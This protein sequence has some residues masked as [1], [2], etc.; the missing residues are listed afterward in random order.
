MNHKPDAHTLTLTVLTA[1][2]FLTLWLPPWLNSW[3]TSALLIFL[4]YRF[5]LKIRQHLPDFSAQPY[6][7][8]LLLGLPLYLLTRTA[9]DHCPHHNWLHWLLWLWIIPLWTTSTTPLHYL[10][11][12]TLSILAQ[13]T[14]SIIFFSLIA[15]HLIQQHTALWQWTYVEWTRPLNLHPN[16]HLLLWC[17]TLIYWYHEPGPTPLRWTT[18]LIATIALILSGSRLLILA[19][20]LMSILLILRIKHKLSIRQTQ[21]A[22]RYILPLLLLGTTLLIAITLFIALD[23]PAIQKRLAQLQHLHNTPRWTYWTC[24]WQIWQQHFFTGTGPCQLPTCLHQ[25][26]RQ[27]LT[28]PTP[29]NINTH[30]QWLQLG[31][32]AGILAPLLWTAILLWMFYQN[33]LPARLW[34]LLYSAF[35]LVDTPL[36][37]HLGHTLLL[38]IGLPNWA[39]PHH[40]S[41]KARTDRFTTG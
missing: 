27:H 29:P 25:C 2:F 33:P 35:A 37:H 30:Q 31:A 5:L 1:L 32:Q 40:S 20:P 28:T 10:S 13:T 21:P 41:R 12:R 18:P 22:K 15:W 3:T 6:T 34:L 8:L 36:S 11:L 23:Q 14:A 24:G 4:T 19:L 38:W 17:M 16:Y 7:L 39:L 26:F 9:L